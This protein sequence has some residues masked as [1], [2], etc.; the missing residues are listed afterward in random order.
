MEISVGNIF[1]ELSRRDQVPTHRRAWHFQEQ[2]LYYLLLGF[3]WCLWAIKPSNLLSLLKTRVETALISFLQT[4]IHSC[5]GWAY[6]EEKKNLLKGFFWPR[7][8]LSLGP[9]S[10][11]TSEHAQ[12]DWI[13]TKFFRPQD[14]FTVSSL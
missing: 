4:K 9:Q 8:Q 13:Q 2:T 10:P 7:M 1:W 3:P 11:R 14:Y 6:Q 12:A 5:L